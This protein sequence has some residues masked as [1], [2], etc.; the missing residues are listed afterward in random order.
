LEWSHPRN[1]LTPAVATRGSGVVLPQRCNGVCDA[2]QRP[3]TQLKQRPGIRTCR[4]PA[5]LQPLAAPHPCTRRSD[6]AAWRR[7][8]SGCPFGRLSSDPHFRL[9]IQTL[10]PK[11][12][13][14][15]KPLSPSTHT[16]AEALAAHAQARLAWRCSVL[17]PMGMKRVTRTQSCSARARARGPCTTAGRALRSSRPDY[18]NPIPVLASVVSTQMAPPRRPLGCAEL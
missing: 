18:P 16:H 13:Y 12:K 3:K 5:P 1:G 17:R 8:P 2:T 9:R 14:S 15:P 7:A 6:R 10:S 4:A 11:L